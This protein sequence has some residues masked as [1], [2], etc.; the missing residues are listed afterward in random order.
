MFNRAGMLT[1]DGRCKTLDDKAN[2]YVRGEAGIA[3][4]LEALD[5]AS[6]FDGTLTAVEAYVAGTAVNQDGKSSALTAPNGPAQQIVMRQA[7]VDADIVSSAI[8]FIQMHGTGTPL[9]DPIEVGAI[10]AVHGSRKGA[11][12]LVAGKTAFGHTEPAAGL[13]GVLHAYTA[14][15]KA[16]QQPIM[17]LSE[18][19]SYAKNSLAQKKGLRLN[20]PRSTGGN[21]L[22]AGACHAGVSSFAFQGTNAHA[23][24]MAGNEI[25]PPEWAERQWQKQHISVLPPACPFIRRGVVSRGAIVFE[26]DLMHPSFS[27]IQSHQV[28]GSAIFPGA[29]YMELMAQS[30]RTIDVLDGGAFTSVA[31]ASPLRMDVREARS[32]KVRCELHTHTGDVFIRSSA[33]HVKG[34]MSRISVAQTPGAV[35][36]SCPERHLTEAAEPLEPLATRYVYDRFREAGLEYGPEFRLLRSIKVGRESA[37]GLL[38]QQAA[39][40]RAE[41]ILNPAVLDCTLQV[42]GLIKGGSSDSTMIPATLEGLTIAAAISAEGV[43]RGLARKSAGHVDS[44]SSISRDL[45]MLGSGNV[46]LCTLVS[47][48]SKAISTA[49]PVARKEVEQEFTYTV[50]WAA[51]AVP[52]EG[53][54]SNDAVYPKSNCALF[55]FGLERDDVA[56]SSAALGVLQGFG[57][58]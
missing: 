12:S 39:Q 55:S 49:A 10:T 42:G 3:L 14:S 23:I 52:G 8:S 35:A 2:G 18:V 27:F 56:G 6:A 45:V 19:N 46:L 58:P 11:M 24:V 34:Q 47:L 54:A 13:L 1:A 15:N 50:D 33:M 16:M 40:A 36:L 41:F 48:Q 22:L 26:V 57:S 44:S 17:H 7:L 25:I 28:G 31:F 30:A 32:I 37:S 21:A 38:G 53:S 9:G 43:V 5:G 4:Y 29:G 51:S 20:L